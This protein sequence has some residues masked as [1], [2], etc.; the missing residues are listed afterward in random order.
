[1]RL[2]NEKGAEAPGKTGQVS[3][4]LEVQRF[5][6][7]ATRF[8]GN[9]CYLHSI[10]EKGFLAHA[11]LRAPCTHAWVFPHTLR[12]FAHFGFEIFVMHCYS[13]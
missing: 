13:P 3:R 9:A 4:K 12:D 5:D 6:P 2:S 11:M 10:R 1:M 7:R 8:V